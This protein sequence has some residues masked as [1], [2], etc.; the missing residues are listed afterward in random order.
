[1]SAYVD[2]EIAVRIAKPHHAGLI[3]TSP[4]AERVEQLLE[5]YTSRFYRDFHATAPPLERATE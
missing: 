4:R 1:M 2:P 5:Q 3:V